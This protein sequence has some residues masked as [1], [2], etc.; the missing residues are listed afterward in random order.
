MDELLRLETLRSFASIAVSFFFSEIKIDM[1]LPQIKELVNAG[2]SDN[3]FKYIGSFKYQNQTKRKILY[4][5]F[6]NKIAT[7]LLRERYIDLFD[8]PDAL[9]Q[10]IKATRTLSTS[11]FSLKFFESSKDYPLSCIILCQRSGSGKTKLMFEVGLRYFPEVYINVSGDFASP[12][13]VVNFIKRLYNLG[14]KRDKQVERARRFLNAMTQIVWNL[15]NSMEVKDPAKL[16][17]DFVDQF[18]PLKMEGNDQEDVWQSII[19][20]ANDSANNDPRK[21]NFVSKVASCEE[22]GG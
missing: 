18:G 14:G 5:T 7:M 12:P 13:N 17:K 6:K 20:T 4:S 21:E 11:I 16:R 9:Y 3:I 1:P 2:R 8:I 19:D 10:W 15:W 22:L